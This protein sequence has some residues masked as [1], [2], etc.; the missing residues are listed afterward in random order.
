PVEGEVGEGEG[1][2]EPV[3][4]EVGEGEGEGEPVEGEVGE[5]EGEGEPV[6]GESEGEDE[7]EGGEGETE[8][9]G[10]EEGEEEGEPEGE[11]EGEQHEGEIG[12]DSAV[13]TCIVRDA[14]TEAPINNATI[15]I[16]PEVAAANNSGNGVYILSD[17][18][19]GYYSITVSAPGYYADR[20]AV[21]VEDGEKADL[22]VG[23]LP[24]PAS[25]GENEEPPAGDEG[26]MIEGEAAPPRWCRGCNCDTAAPENTRRIWGDWLLVGLGL[27]VLRCLRRC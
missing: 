20:H 5:G 23:L 7:G 26:E 8:P 21:V 18:P 14:E 10:E 24:I 16:V 1:E 13:I 22:F 6:E 12:E 9:E 25:E 2:G 11:D 17:L 19:A 15:R 27:L 4:G 3:E